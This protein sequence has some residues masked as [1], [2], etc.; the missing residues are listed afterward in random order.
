MGVS[1]S[2][3]SIELFANLLGQV[4]VPASAPDFEEQAAK[5]AKAKREITEALD[6]P[7]SS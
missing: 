1:L 4:Q 2:R 3:E 6:G 5:V 7:E